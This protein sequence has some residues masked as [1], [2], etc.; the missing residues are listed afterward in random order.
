[1]EDDRYLTLEERCEAVYKEKSSKFLAFA[2]PVQSEEEIR[3]IVDTLKKR[4][5]DATHH[6]YAWRLG[7]HGDSFR[8]ND[9]GEPSGTAGKPILGQLL[10]HGI[11]YCL[12]VVVRYFGGTKLGV[13]GL[14]AAYKESACAVIEAGKIT[15]RT[16]DKSVTVHFPYIAMNDVMRIVKESAPNVMEQTFD[17][18][19]SMTLSVRAGKFAELLGR[20]QKVDGITIEEDEQR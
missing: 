19:C 17:N 4:Y 12:I 14:I 9:D 8:S 1:M 7:A 15:E 6:C 20:L 16:V 11:T 2:Y 18:V 3:E 5:Y 13:S 10:S